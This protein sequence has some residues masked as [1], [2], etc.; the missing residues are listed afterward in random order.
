MPASVFTLVV[1]PDPG[2]EFR[3]VLSAIK[4][5]ELADCIY[6]QND[7]ELCDPDNRA[8]MVEARRSSLLSQNRRKRQTEAAE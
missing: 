1:K 3:T 7:R 4:W 5:G 2:S 6:A 8:A